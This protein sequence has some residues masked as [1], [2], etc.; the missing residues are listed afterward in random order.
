MS[1]GITSKS[2]RK[3]RL[4]ICNGC[5]KYRPNAK[6]LFGLIKLKGKPQC[7]ACKCLINN[8]VIFEDIKCSHPYFDKWE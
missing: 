5:D 4:D 1:L 6:F 3:R 2:E 8:L 7:K